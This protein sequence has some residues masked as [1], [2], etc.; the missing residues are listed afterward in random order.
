MLSD[1]D[2]AKIRKKAENQEDK[3][4]INEIASVGVA[5]LGTG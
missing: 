1:G 5:K 3:A 4:R 2:G